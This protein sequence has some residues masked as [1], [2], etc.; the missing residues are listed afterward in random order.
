MRR[1]SIDSSVSQQDGYKKTTDE[2]RNL[3]ISKVCKEGQKLT[4]VAKDLK[5]NYKTAFTIVDLFRKSGREK[6]LL[7]IKK[8]P[9]KITNEVICYIES[10]VERD[11]TITLKEIQMKCLDSFGITL[12][13]ESVR[14]SLSMT[15]ITLKRTTLLLERVNDEERLELRKLYA[16][17]FLTNSSIDD[18]KNIFV[19][20]SGFNLHLRRSFGRSKKGSRVCVSVP[21]VRGANVTFLSAI[22]SHGVLHH[23]IFRGSC[24]SNI[25]SDFLQ[26]LDQKLI[27]VHNITDGTIFFDNARAHTSEYSK[28]VMRGLQNNTKFISPYSFMLNPIEFSFSKI[29]SLVKRMLSEN[30]NELS[31]HDLIENAISQITSDDATGWYGLMRRNCAL[32]M[33]KNV[34][35]T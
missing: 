2:V 32:A 8:T 9:T 16:T 17:D 31:I 4:D 34:F 28:N 20:E 13:K 22:N 21:T 25:F 10:T 23:K 7:K 11:P 6:R 3:I 19:D 26:E 18:T 33:N 30:T 35:N 24:N 29:K 5:V 12:S 1:N 15:K 14:K 27:T